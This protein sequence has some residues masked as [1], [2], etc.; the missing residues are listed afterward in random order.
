MSPRSWTRTIL[1]A[2]FAVGGQASGLGAQVVQAPSQ[3]AMELQEATHSRL[4]FDKEVV[5]IAVGDSNVMSVEILD[6]LELLALGL[7]PGQTSLFVWFADG[8]TQTLMFRVL[9][10]LSVLRAALVD[11]QFYSAG[12]IDMDIAFDKVAK[13]TASDIS[14]AMPSDYFALLKPRVMSLVVFTALVGL[15]LAPGSIN[16]F[17]ARASMIS[18]RTVGLTD[19]PFFRAKK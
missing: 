1:L 10:D 2:A 3:Q 8:T 7:G 12:S 6:S 19:G 11:E 17:I 9:P 5:R 14:V 18:N 13:A 15:V 16:P 4:T